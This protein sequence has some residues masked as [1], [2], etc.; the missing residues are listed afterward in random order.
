MSSTSSRSYDAIVIGTGQAGKPLARS[1][2]VAG[3]R[4]A[5]LERDHVG[6]SCVNFG[7][8]PTKTMVASARVAYLARSASRWG[9]RAEMHGVDMTAV[10]SRKQEV[11]ERFRSG[12]QSSLEALDGLDLIFGHGRFTAPDTVEVTLRDGSRQQLQAPKIFVNTGT[13]SARPR[14][15]GLER[16]PFLQDTSILE[17]GELPGHLLVLGGGYIGVELGQ[18]FRRFGSRVTVVQ[19][20]GQLLGRE[21]QDVAAAVKEILE[22]DGVE[23]H[24]STEALAVRHE[25]GRMQIGVRGPG[26]QHRLEGTH[27]LLAAGRAPNTADLGLDKAGVETDGRGFIRANGRLETSVP[28]IYALGDVK[29]GPAF[30]HIS[31]DDYRVVEHNLLEGGARTI[32]GRMVPYTVFLDPQLG[33]IGLTEAEAREQGLRFRV[34]RLPMHNVARA[35]EMGETRGFLK[36]VVE[37]GTDR[38]LGFAALGVEGGELAGAVQIAMMGGLPAA[39]LRDGIFSHPTLLESLNNLFATLDA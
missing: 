10:R 21:D 36:A 13:R 38:I 5:V 4:V 2:A 33:R 30:T 35:I 16:V 27:L 39:A 24:L 23:V 15:E 11:V 22:E 18:M 8:T 37:E 25:D 20:G 31:Y 7:C 12:S 29:G 14:L 26:G 6:G 32:D 3:W 1:L 19:R 9:V 34:A 28:G 17:L